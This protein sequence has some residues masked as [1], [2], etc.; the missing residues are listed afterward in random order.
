MSDSVSFYV[1]A[2][3]ILTTFFTTGVFLYA[4]KRGS[5]S[6][7]TTQILNFLLPFWL[8]FQAVMAL[9]GFYLQTDSFPPRLFLFALLPAIL[10]VILLFVFA[11]RDFISRLPLKTLTWI[12]VVRIPVEIVL[13]WLFQ[14]KLVPQLMTFEGRN[15]DILAGITAPLVAWL[16]FRDGKINRNLLLIWNVLAFFLLIN[17][18]VNAILSIPSPIQKFAFDDPNTAVLYFPFVWLPV[19]VVPIVLFCHLASFWQLLKPS[20]KSKL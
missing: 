14:A 4:A 5:F 8:I 19:I 16:A 1:S 13:F 15:F 18:L 2:L 3:F 12:H 17:I 10:T 7:K 20:A 9:G 6:S 11:R